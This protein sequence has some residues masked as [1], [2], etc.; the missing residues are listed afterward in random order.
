MST[1]SI[2]KPKAPIISIVNGEII[3]EDDDISNG[4]IEFY[5]NGEKFNGSLSS[6]TISGIYTINA[7]YVFESE[8]IM[9]SN[10]SNDIIV[11]KIETPVVSVENGLIKTL[12]DSKLKTYYLNGEIFDGDLSKIV[13]PGEYTITIRY[14]STSAYEIQSEL[15]EEVV[16]IR[17]SAPLIRIN[18]SMVEVES[19]THDVELLL[20]GVEFD[21]DLSKVSSLENAKI[22]A[23]SIGDNCTELHSVYSELII[24]RLP[25]PVISINEGKVV[26]DNPSY[27]SELF[28]NGKK[29]DGSLS[30]IVEAGIYK[31]TA[32]YVSSSKEF[33]N[34]CY[35]NEISITKLPTPIVT[36]EDNTLKVDKSYDVKYFLNGVEFDGNL[37]SI[38]TAGN[39]IITAKYIHDGDLELDSNISEDY[40]LIK[41]NTPVIFIVGGELKTDSEQYEV[42]WYANGTPIDNI[43]SLSQGNY[44]ITA[45]YLK[46]DNHEL[47]SEASSKVQVFKLGTPEIEIKDHKVVIKKNDGEDNVDVNNIC[48]FVDGVEFDGDYSKLSVGQ[49]SFTAIN[50]AT[51]FGEINSSLS[52]A[53]TM[54]KP[55]SPVI[56]LKEGYFTSDENLRYFYVYNDEIVQFNGKM[57]SLPIGYST[58]YAYYSSTEE[59]YL[60]SEKSNELKIYRCGVKISGAKKETQNNTYKLTIDSSSGVLNYYYSVQLYDENDEVF[61][62]YTSPNSNTNSLLTVNYSR[63]IDGQEIVA[64]KMKIVFI[65]KPD[66]SMSEYEDSYEVFIAN[67]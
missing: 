1:V 66:A 28:I 32:I 18:G 9:D 15:S 3:N 58:V 51:N 26:V 25:T 54:Y 34:S 14:N 24:S 29:F 27:N 53:I 21:G 6:V 31:I 38:K 45:V 17:L 63:I 67:I 35:S 10:L 33:I 64:K 11:N 42:Q 12:D 8:T 50:I 55:E 39:H 61:A 47:N 4:Q 57:A 62:T 49:H 40:N 48:L 41:I 56:E 19:G 2:M 65:T 22:T 44:N 20:N 13:T 7:R 5:L 16:V 60:V 23:R 46:K 52:A 36:V 43:N 37:T 30:S 59:N